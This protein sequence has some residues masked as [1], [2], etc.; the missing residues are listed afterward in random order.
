MRVAVTIFTLGLVLT[1][2]KHGH[3]PEKRSTEAE[4]R[5]HI[6]GTW[7]S[8]DRP[9]WRSWQAITLG[10]D[11]TFVTTGANESEDLAGTWRIEGRMLVV[12]TTKTN[13]ATLANVET[14]PLGH[15]MFYP[16]V[17]V[18][19]H[20]LVCTPGISVAGRLRFRR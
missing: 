6:G 13:Y 7:I 14:L 16:I 2:C 4:I 15:V 3:G 5:Q 20:E 9:D 1:A 10:S 11:G 12:T 18:N 19:D 8:D 17:Y